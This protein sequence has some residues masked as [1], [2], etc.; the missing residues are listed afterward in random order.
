MPAKS[1]EPK[2]HAWGTCWDCCGW[3]LREKCYETNLAR[4]VEQKTMCA[5]ECRERSLIGKSASQ[6]TI[7]IYAKAKLRPRD[8]TSRMLSMSPYMWWPKALKFFLDS[9]CGTSLSIGTGSHSS[10]GR[11]HGAWVSIHFL[12]CTLLHQRLTCVL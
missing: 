5:P 10:S 12:E 9:G 3:P 2:I 4:H 11:F 7:L 8:N 6:N 1:T